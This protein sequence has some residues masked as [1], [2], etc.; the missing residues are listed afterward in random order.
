MQVF[1]WHYSLLV[2]ISTS[3]PGNS[4]A[5]S[6]GD[7]QKCHGF[8]RGGCPFSTWDADHS[9]CDCTDQYDG[10]WWFQDGCSD[11]NLNDV[12]QHQASLVDNQGVVWKQW[13]DTDYSLKA[14]QMKI[15]RKL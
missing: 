1:Y 8:Y 12:Y 13:M 4:L 15:R 7:G 6:C 10:G 3:I 11:S 2:G 5:G 14:T 9:D